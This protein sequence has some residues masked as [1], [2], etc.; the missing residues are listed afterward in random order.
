[1]N[2]ILCITNFGVADEL[3]RENRGKNLD[4]HMDVK[5]RED[6]SAKLKLKFPDIPSCQHFAKILKLF[7]KG[8]WH[9]YATQLDIH[10][11]ALYGKEI[12]QEAAKASKSTASMVVDQLQ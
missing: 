9:F 2:K 1:M 4:E 6:I 8:K 3:F 10:G 7:M 12:D 5:L 11:H